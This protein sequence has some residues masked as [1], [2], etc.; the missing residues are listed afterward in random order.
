MQI[1]QTLREHLVRL[2]DWEDAH[3]NF[4]TVLSNWPST[5]RGVKPPGC[6]HS[7]WQLLEHLRI[8]QWDI[9][10]FSRNPD[11]VSPDFPSGYWPVDEHPPSD[12]AWDASVARF[13]GNL[14]EMKALIMN[15]A[16]DLY[17]AIAHG[18]GQT[19][20]REALLVADHNSYHLG[21]LVSLAR[22]LGHWPRCD[23]A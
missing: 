18:Q 13:R 3:A 12:A 15:P 4:N 16:V 9:L 6:V 2:L 7:A 1:Q 20:L 10:E 8:C 19:V 5:L 23:S 11:H 22:L 17:T 21:Q 14:E